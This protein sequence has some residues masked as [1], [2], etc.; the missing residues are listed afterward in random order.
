MQLP[1]WFFKR[2]APDSP[3]S[4]SAESTFYSSVR[5]QDGEDKHLYEYYM[6]KIIK[7]N[8]FFLELGALDGV[9]FSNTIA[10]EKA[11]GWRGILIE[12]G[13]TNYG[14]LVRNRPDNI[15]VNMASCGEPAT[16]HFVEQEA[17]GGIVEFMSDKF[18]QERHPS[19]RR[20][21]LR[22]LPTLPC[23]PLSSVLRA[24]R[25]RHI[26]L[27][28]VDVEGAELEVLRTVNFSDVH[29][30]YVIVEADGSNPEKEQEV[31][32]YMQMSGFRFDGNKMRSDWFISDDIA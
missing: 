24:F 28:S 12:P 7:P 9:M 26:D 22:G 11:F 17:V 4:A 19:I 10:F 23:F 6:S 3:I 16:V 21:N 30:N 14:R 18:L 25:V 15:L 5:S 8:G 29:V 1:H 20:D 13:T 31:R 32:H 2:K 27:L